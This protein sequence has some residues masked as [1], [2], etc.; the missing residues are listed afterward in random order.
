MT[1]HSHLRTSDPG[2]KVVIVVEDLSEELPGE[3][4]EPHKFHDGSVEVPK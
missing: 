2:K 4:A 1:A 3:A